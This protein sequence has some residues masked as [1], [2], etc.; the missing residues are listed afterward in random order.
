[1]TGNDLE[2]KFR[3][4]ERKI[5]K[6]K[7]LERVLDSLDTEGFE[8][9][10]KEIKSMIKSPDKIPLIEKGIE[11]LN[12][13]IGKKFPNLLVNRKTNQISIQE[14]NVLEMTIEI[15]NEGE[16]VARSVSFLDKINN[17]LRMISGENSWTDNLN[18][19]ELKT[20][21]YTL[22]AEKAGKYH[23]PPLIVHYED[24]RGEKYEKSSNP[25]EIEV[26]PKTK[27]ISKEQTQKNTYGVVIGIGKY[28]DSSIP[29][30]K[31]AK[32]DAI[33]IY[34]ILTDPKYG[35]FPEENIRLLLD[36]QA[37]LTEIKSAM[38]TFLARQ[39][40][41]DDIV[42]IF[43][44]GHGSPE[45]DPTGKTDDNLEKFIVP[46]D[47]KKDDLY[48]SGLSMD[49]IKKI[50]ER[51][52][53]KSIISFIDSCYSGEAGGRTFA[54]G[55]FT[56]KNI[57]ISDKFLDQLSGEGRIII[58][59]SK[60]DELSLEADELKHGIFSYYLAEGLKGKADLDEDGV[61]TIDELYRY[62]YENVTKKARLLGTTQHPLKKG[63]FI[64]E[65][66][67]THCETGKM[68]KI[69]ELD[70]QAI[71]FFKK[72]EFEAAIKRWEEIIKIDKENSKSLECIAKS[73]R[74]IKV[75]KAIVEEKQ[76]KLINLHEKGLPS[77][78]FDE[79]MTILKKVKSSYTEIDKKILYYVEELLNEHISIQTY[80]DTR[81]L[82]EKN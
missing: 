64:G 77:K 76:R 38:G 65:I 6:L 56:A 58:T 35:N 37:T 25:I 63:T 67:L 60:P 46:Y 80:I 11:E 17:G 13:K 7:K 68:R 1:M 59:A 43:F 10:V 57:T 42:C 31:Y 54:R 78:E 34:N 61:V 55:G 47:A 12:V 45:L 29:I 79:A 69:K 23:I 22:K 81:K 26:I 20:F 40:G 4:F 16:D 49:D 73:K 15:K 27:E 21:I 70:S 18:K 39:A 53:S 9:E 32:D 14:G 71:D 66:P 30:L 41:K 52:E 36:E 51:I 48:S 75:Q 74:E 50:Y 5:E 19:N 2:N 8:S 62:I 72:G 24:N 28:E 3:E 82:I 44:A 33:E